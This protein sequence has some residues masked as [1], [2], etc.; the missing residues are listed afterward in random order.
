MNKL[1]FEE[2]VNA[3]DNLAKVIREIQ[4]HQYKLTELRNKKRQYQDFIS[5]NKDYFKKQV[6]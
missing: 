1:T 3:V 5:R 2:K 4:F 6:K